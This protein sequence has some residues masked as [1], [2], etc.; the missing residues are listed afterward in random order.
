MLFHLLHLHY[1]MKNI[2]LVLKKNASV[3]QFKP[4]FPQRMIYVKQ[5]K[6]CG[7]NLISNSSL[8]DLKRDSKKRLIKDGGR[9][10][11]I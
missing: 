5:E 7:K 10:R 8:A 9:N 4:S 11:S 6:M 2:E 3:N 1:D